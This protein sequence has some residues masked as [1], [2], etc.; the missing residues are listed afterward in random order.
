MCN[1]FDLN[2]VSQ[3]D[4][5]NYHSLHGLLGPKA[6]GTVLPGMASTL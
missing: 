6:E 3:S 2:K 5:D 4:D 1:K